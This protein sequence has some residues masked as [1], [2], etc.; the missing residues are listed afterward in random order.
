MIDN[1]FDLEPMKKPEGSCNG[2]ID[3]RTNL[4]FQLGP[5]Y[6]TT[7]DPHQWV[8]WMN[9]NDSS[10]LSIV[11]FTLHRTEKGIRPVDHAI[12]VVQADRIREWLDFGRK[13]FANDLEKRIGEFKPEFHHS[14]RR[15]VAN[16]RR[17]A[18]EYAI[19]CAIVD[20]LGGIEAFLDYLIAAVRACNVSSRPTM[21][22]RLGR[23]W[24]QTVDVILV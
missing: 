23:D 19:R 3:R 2:W 14:I 18:K 17:F 4:G 21:P 13:T 15:L 7:D 5:E 12:Y 16:H 20:R 8:F 24:A 10:A 9:L 22:G 11:W 1:R 6:R